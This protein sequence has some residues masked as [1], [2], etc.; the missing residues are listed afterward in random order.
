MILRALSVRVSDLIRVMEIAKPK[1]DPS[2]NSWPTLSSP[3][4]GR[5]ITTTPI[6][7]ST[8]AAIFKRV[9]RS[10]RKIAAMMAIQ[11][12]MVNS[13]ETSWLRGINVN[14]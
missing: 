2:E 11:I 13:I 12:G 5:T 10:P 3:A 9:I 4:V 1:A 6:R 14:A 8:M 7:P